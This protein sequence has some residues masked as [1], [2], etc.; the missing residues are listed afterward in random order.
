MSEPDFTGVDFGEHKPSASGDK[1][2][3]LSALVTQ[4]EMAEIEVETCEAALKLAKERLRGIVEHEL[5][6][7]MMELKQPILHTTDGRKITI[8]DVVRATLPEVNR[9][10]GFQWLIDHGHSGIVKRTVEVAFAA[11]EGDKAQELL[12]EMEGEY[13]ANAREVM[14]VEPSTLT[15][16][17]KDQI[18]AGEELPQDIFQIREFKHAKISKK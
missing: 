11:V 18:E 3:Q 2:E 6:E 14:K 16:F 17:V 13:G 8:K 1:L 9:P 4:M 12:H 5:P 7:L 10:K 15:R